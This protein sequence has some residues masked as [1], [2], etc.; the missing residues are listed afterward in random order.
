MGCLPYQPVQD[1]FHHY[2][3]GKSPS[4][5]V[6]DFSWLSAWSGGEIVPSAWCEAWAVREPKEDMNIPIEEW[7]QKL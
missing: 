6:T 5:R 4:Q 2:F 3:D 1:F 7:Q